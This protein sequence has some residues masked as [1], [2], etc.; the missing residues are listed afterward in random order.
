MGNER[1]VAED[2]SISYSI[3]GSSTYDD[4]FLFLFFWAGLRDPTS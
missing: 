3:D 2:K 1:N 4:L